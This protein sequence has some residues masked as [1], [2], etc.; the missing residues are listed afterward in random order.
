MNVGYENYNTSDVAQLLG[1]Q[2]C[3]VSL[4]CRQR[5]IRYQDVS[6][7]GSSRPRYLFDEDEVNRVSKLIDKYGKKNW[8]LHNH[9]DEEKPVEAAAITTILGITNPEEYI[10]DDTDEAIRYIKQIRAL[11]VQRDK[12]LA[13]IDAKNV[14][15]NNIENA[16]ETMRSKVIETI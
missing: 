15:L 6:S 12:I 1:V 2:K 16:I 13:E 3:T 5:L 4:W 7:P 14:E 8:I 9:V 11:K 10:P